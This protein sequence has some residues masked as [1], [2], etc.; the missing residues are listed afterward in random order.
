MARPAP[1]RWNMSSCRICASSGPSGLSD[2]GPQLLGE[3][4]DP[5]RREMEA[6]EAPSPSANGVMTVGLRMMRARRSQRQPLPGFR[7]ADSWMR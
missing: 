1:P 2:R 5:R 3:W 4:L 7:K 6:A